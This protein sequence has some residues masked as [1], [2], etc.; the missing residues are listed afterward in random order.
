MNP[1]YLLDTNICIYISKKRPPEVFTR[2][3]QLKTG[4]IAMSLITY[5]ELYYGAQKSQ[6]RETAQKN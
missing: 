4:D 1:D 6:Y 2:F 3:K 5:G